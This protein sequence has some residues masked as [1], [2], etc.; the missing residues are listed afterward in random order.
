MQWGLFLLALAGCFSAGISFHLYKRT[1]RFKFLGL[2]CASIFFI[3]INI[4][5]IIAPS[6]RGDVSSIIITWIVQGAHI[7][8]IAL[9]LSSLLLFARESKP[10]FMR[11]PILYT[12]FPLLII[13]SYALVYDT[14]ILRSWLLNIY[15][16]GAIVV[17]LLIYGFYSYEEPIYRTLFT[18][19]VLFLISFI[20]YFLLSDS[21]EIIW[22]VLLAISIGTAFSGYLQVESQSKKQ[23]N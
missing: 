17:S 13:I 19:A 18:G 16:A 20:L 11:F 5:L 4:G 1:D 7:C 15:E 23:F 8:C 9:V 22:Q 10:V 14:A 12:A 21:Y 2:F 3:I 6:L